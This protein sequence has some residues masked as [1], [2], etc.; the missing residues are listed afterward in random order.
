MEYWIEGSPTEFKIIADAVGVKFVG[1]SEVFVKPSDFNELA[2]AI[3]MA[4]TDHTG[5]RR[6]LRADLQGGVS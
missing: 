3:G 1:E 5:L 2:R 4:A 6:A